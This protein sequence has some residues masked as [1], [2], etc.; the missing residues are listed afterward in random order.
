MGLFLMM[1]GFKFQH[2][3]ISTSRFSLVVLEIVSQ[4]TVSS[5]QHVRHREIIIVGGMFTHADMTS[6]TGRKSGQ[7]RCPWKYGRAKEKASFRIGGQAT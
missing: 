1:G 2:L 3:N 6:V 5:F 7:H 4:L